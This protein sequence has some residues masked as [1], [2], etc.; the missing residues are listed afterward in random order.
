MRKARLDVRLSV[1]ATTETVTVQANAVMVDTTT[2]TLKAVVDQK[3]I[4][5]L[6]LNGRN[7]TQRAQP[8]ESE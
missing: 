5:E 7:A 2:S 8:G 4:E 3:R 1:G 6:P